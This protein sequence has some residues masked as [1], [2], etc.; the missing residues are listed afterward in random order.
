MSHQPDAQQARGQ[1]NHKQNHPYLNFSRNDR[2]KRIAYG[3][4]WNADHFVFF[5]TPSDTLHQKISVGQIRQ[6]H[7]IVCI[8]LFAS[9]CNQPTLDGSSIQD[10]FPDGADCHAERRIGVSL[11]V[12]EH[13]RC[14]GRRSK[15]LLRLAFSLADICLFQRNAGRD[16]HII[17]F[18]GK[19]PV[20]FMGNIGR[21]NGVWIFVHVQR[22]FFKNT[23]AGL[24]APLV[25]KRGKIR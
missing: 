4:A 7:Q 12:I 9:D 20:D 14:A 5:G 23:F 25:Q 18:T 11:S 6:R 8:N 24:D 13:R 19:I 17:A 16:D 2:Q 21:R 1:E 15:H 22:R 3:F 10:G